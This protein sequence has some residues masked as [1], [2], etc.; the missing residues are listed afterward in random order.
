MLFRF[1]FPIL[2]KVLEPKLVSANDT[3]NAKHYDSMKYKLNLEFY[4]FLKNRVLKK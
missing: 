4:F 2:R 3:N 1:I